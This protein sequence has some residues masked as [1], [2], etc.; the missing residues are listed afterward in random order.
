[1]ADFP[2]AALRQIGIESDG[3]ETLDN[4]MDMFELIIEACQKK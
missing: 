4:F 3:S 1:M 2:T